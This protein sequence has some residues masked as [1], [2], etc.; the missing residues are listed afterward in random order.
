MR[1]YQNG[2]LRKEKRK[3]GLDVWTYRWR[4]DGS[5]KKEII[6]T[7][8]D[9]KT[10]SLAWKAI[11]N[12][13]STINRDRPTPRNVD[14]LVKHYAEKELTTKTPTTA[15]VCAL[16]SGHDGSNEQRLERNRPSIGPQWTQILTCATDDRLSKLRWLNRLDGGRCRI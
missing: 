9:Y 16:R 11:E 10:K 7:V 8:E 3:N 13:R 4:A 6:G 14:N 15:E 5:R 2:S 1:S 12:L